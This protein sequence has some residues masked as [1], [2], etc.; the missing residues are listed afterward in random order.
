MKI[1]SQPDFTKLLIDWCIYDALE[2]N[3]NSLAIKL[4]LP[5]HANGDFYFFENSRVLVPH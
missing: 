5:M 4:K 3:P 1:I 2:S